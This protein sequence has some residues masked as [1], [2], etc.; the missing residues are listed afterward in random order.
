MGIWETN[1]PDETASSRGLEAGMFSL[2]ARKG[3]T[4]VTGTAS[5]GEILKDE[6]KYGRQGRS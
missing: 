3:E 6:I 1:D 4:N 2:C 5:E